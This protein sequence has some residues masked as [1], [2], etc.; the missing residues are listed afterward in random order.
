M[1]NIISANQIAFISDRQILDGFMMANEV[2]HNVKKNRQHGF[3]M[4]VDFYKAFDS[5]VWEYL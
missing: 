2:V 5:V 4:K 3:V 1:P